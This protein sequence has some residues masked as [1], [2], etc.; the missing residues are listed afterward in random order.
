MRNYTSHV[1]RNDSTSNH[2]LTRLRKI[3]TMSSPVTRCS[4]E[5]LSDC[6]TLLCRYRRVAP[7][8][9]TAHQ[10]AQGYQQHA[11]PC[12]GIEQVERRQ[13]ITLAD[14]ALRHGARGQL[15]AQSKLM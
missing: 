10:K 12:R 9:G 1:R 3:A 11:E 2:H 8:G 15:I 6:I 13:E 7:G 14:H 4:T 5:N